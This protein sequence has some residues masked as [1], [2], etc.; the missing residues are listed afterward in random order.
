MAIKAVCAIFNANESGSQIRAS[1]QGQ[2]VNGSGTG[3]TFNQDFDCDPTLPN[4]NTQI[5]ESVKTY[6]I[7]VKGVT[8]NAGDVIVFFPAIL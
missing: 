4:V 7:N 6:L 2:V 8:F 5:Y 3:P 1:V